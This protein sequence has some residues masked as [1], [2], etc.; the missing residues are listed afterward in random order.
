M[1]RILISVRRFAIFCHRWMG[2]V[3]CL[4]FSWWFVSGIFMMYW[5][6]PSVSP[7]DRLDRSKPIDVSKIHISPREAWAKLGLNH[8]P[9]G[10]RLEMFDERPVYR[11]PPDGGG[12]GGRR[13]GRGGRGGG[14]APAIV[15]ADDGSVQQGYSKEML[16]RIAAAWTRQ[17]A[18]AARVEEVT[19][20]DQ[21]TVQAGLRALRPLWKYSFPDGRQVYVSGASG[22]VV[23]YT[24]TGSRLGAWLGAIP[25]WLYFTPLRTQQKLWSNIIIWSSGIGTIMALLGLIVGIS[26]YSP[27]QKYR[28]KKIPSSIPYS[29]QKRLHMTLGLF[30][31]ILTC[32]WAF[33]GMLSMDP[34]FLADQRRPGATG[35]R[36]GRR[37]ADNPAT[38]VQA[39]LRPGPFDISA[40]DYKAPKVALMDLGGLPVKQ[41]DFTSFDGQPVYMASLGAGQTRIV[42]VDG[43]PMA[44]FDRARILDMVIV[45]ALP[46]PLTESR[47]MTQYD[48]YYLDRHHERPLPVV[49]VRL[50]DPQHSQFYIDQRTGRIVGQYSDNSS[51]VTRWLYHGLHSMDFP[52]LYNHRPAWDIVVLT[53]MLGGLSLSVTSVIM[54][55]RVM[56]RTL[57]AI[58]GSRIFQGLS[59]DGNNQLRQFSGG[60][61][62]DGHSDERIQH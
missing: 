30:F 17:A 15:Y 16:L 21:W 53:L 38:R 26:M 60:I 12:R 55:R 9:A 52:W 23:Q 49:F 61:Q 58:A 10:A 6:F 27:S 8:P 13:A 29:G 54:G 39:A 1:R 5:D 24:T 37:E 50:N 22:E 57:G 33:S 28:F 11:F 45:A 59:S 3:F 56:R 19:Q 43:D 46:V 51:F 2:V 44:E 42:P 40:Y 7:A 4:L 41:L 48:A 25:H 36:G 62:A 35:G 14:N 20:V 32:T 47:L 18:G 34:P 31:G